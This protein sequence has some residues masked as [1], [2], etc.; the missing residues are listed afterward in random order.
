MTRYCSNCGARVGEADRFCRSCG[1]KLV[2]FHS[3]SQ[4]LPEITAR[5]HYLGFF[6]LGL[7]LACLGFVTWLAIPSPPKSQDIPS[8]MG[9]ELPADHPPIEGMNNGEN[10]SATQM[11][12]FIMEA[13]SRLR[14][15]I[16]D[17]PNDVNSRVQLASM[18]YQIG[19]FDE[20]L[21]YLDEALK[22][23]PTN[24]EALVMAGNACYDTDQFE[25]G[26][27]YYS[28]ALIIEPDNLDVRTDMGVLFL[29]KGNPDQAIKEFKRVLEAKGDFI[30]AMINLSQAYLARGNKQLALSTLQEALAKA[31]TDE[32]RE[33]IRNRIDAISATN[34]SI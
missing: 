15:N 22:V 27:S 4:Q 17:N 18:Y 19:R 14:K 24:L 5:R 9:G 2:D 29:K 12:A 20:A 13:L 28:R 31:H 33:E 1:H 8:F 3:G 7:V 34:G 23:D 26:I 6:V 25:R 21:K 30:P 11:P 10:P 32:E 16:E